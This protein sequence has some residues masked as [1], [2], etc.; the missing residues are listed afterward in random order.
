MKRGQVAPRLLMIVFSWVILLS[1]LALM[2]ILQSFADDPTP[3]P[4]AVDTPNMELNLATFLRQTTTFAG[5]NIPMAEF[6]A[7]A[8]MD[9]NEKG[10]KQEAESFLNRLEG[11][12]R[13]QLVFTLPNGKVLTY[14]IEKVSGEEVKSRRSAST[15]IPLP[16]RTTITIEYKETD[17]KIA[18]PDI[19]GP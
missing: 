17:T 13:A 19:G 8:A 12:P 9:G 18:S 4:D 3:L 7:I 2:F 15:T 1:V 10:I 5:D 11:G 14:G 16:D 6:L